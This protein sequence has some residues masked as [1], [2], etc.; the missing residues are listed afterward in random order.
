MTEKFD[1]SSAETY[2]SWKIEWSYSMVKQDFEV[3]R[4]KT[5]KNEK[6][7]HF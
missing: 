2:I 5:K 1:K 7:E 3:P 6:V 4:F